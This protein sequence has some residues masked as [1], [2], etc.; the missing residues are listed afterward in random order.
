MGISNG[1]KISRQP[2]HKGVC[3]VSKFTDEFLAGFGFAEL[4][5]SGERVYIGPRALQGLPIGRGDEVDIVLDR[6][7]YPG[8]ARAAFRVFVSKRAVENP[9]EVTTLRGEFE[10]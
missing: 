3:V 6:K 2:K 10:V 7:I 5:G 8:K 4:A 9:D 1:S